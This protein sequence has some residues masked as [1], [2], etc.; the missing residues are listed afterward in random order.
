MC[1]VTMASKLV[2]PHPTL[3]QL[4]DQ[5]C[6][7]VASGKGRGLTMCVYNLHSQERAGNPHLCGMS[8]HKLAKGPHYFKL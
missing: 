7:V 4:G 3:Q 2:L 5:G 1:K 6:C 8:M